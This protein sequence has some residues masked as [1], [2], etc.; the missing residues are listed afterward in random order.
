MFQIL[1]VIVLLS[2]VEALSMCSLKKYQNNSGTIY[3]VI[4]VILY[5]VVCALLVK[6]YGFGKIGLINV[7]WSGLSVIIVLLFGI[8]FFKEAVHFHDIIAIALIMTGISI[9]RVTD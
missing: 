3:F 6:L 8:I 1:L 5:S 2:I 9:I 7:L 4:A